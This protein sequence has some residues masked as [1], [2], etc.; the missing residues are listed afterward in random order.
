MN[1]DE[2]VATTG[3]L[4]QTENAWAFSPAPLPP[5]LDSTWP[6]LHAA[7]IADR[8]VGTLAGIGR[9]LPNPELLIKP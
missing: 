5:E 3:Q 8:A 7:T 9:T 6:L 2:F 1:A 4:I